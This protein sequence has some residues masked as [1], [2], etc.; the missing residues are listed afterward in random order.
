M[1]LFPGVVGTATD[2]THCDDL[3]NELRTA[4]PFRLRWISWESMELQITKISNYSTRSPWLDSLPLQISRQLNKNKNSRHST[5]TT[6]RSPDKTSAFILHLRPHWHCN[7][8]AS[9]GS[10]SR[11]ELRSLPRGEVEQKKGAP[12][13]P[14]LIKTRESP[15]FKCTA[16]PVKGNNARRVPMQ[17]APFSRPMRA[18]AA[19]III[20]YPRGRTCACARSFRPILYM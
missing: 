11:L 20:I 19:R 1:S 8:N 15:S 13:S 2:R 4:V 6:S 5:R 17:L 9:S 16:P 3:S 14:K 18:G 7:F 10:T 12:L